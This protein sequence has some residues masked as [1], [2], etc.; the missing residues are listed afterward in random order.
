MLQH[1]PNSAGVEVPGVGWL[2]TAQVEDPIAK[3]EKDYDAITLA[4]PRAGVAIS[5]ILVLG[6]PM[7][8]LSGGA[9]MSLETTFLCPPDMPRC[10]DPGPTGPILIGTGFMVLIGG[11]VGLV[12]TT[13]KLKQKKKERRRIE[14]AIDRHKR[15]LPN[16]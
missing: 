13:R 14:L 5:S 4:G 8:I 16:P 11:V 1:S 12:L 9:I 15:S 7:M 2:T 10:G 6:G 3:L